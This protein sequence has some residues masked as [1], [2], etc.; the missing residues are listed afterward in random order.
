MIFPHTE[1]KACEYCGQQ[2]SHTIHNEF[3]DSIA[4]CPGCRTRFENCPDPDC[5]SDDVSIR[6]LTPA[7]PGENSF[8]R[9]ECN[10]CGLTLAEY[11]CCEGGNI[12]DVLYMWENGKDRIAVLRRQ[13]AEAKKP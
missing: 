1:N 10:V 5:N 4:L 9:I 3:D 7:R 2:F 12:K 13:E 8:Y 11:V 6:L